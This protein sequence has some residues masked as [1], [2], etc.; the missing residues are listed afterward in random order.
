MDVEIVKLEIL[1]HEQLSVKGIAIA[2]ITLISM[3]ATT[4]LG[5]IAITNY[6]KNND[7]K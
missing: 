7:W 6:C 1:L 3:P 4:V 2:I 5:N